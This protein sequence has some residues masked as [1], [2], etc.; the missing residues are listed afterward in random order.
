MLFYEQMGSANAEGDESGV[1]TIASGS[2]D[3][4]AVTNETNGDLD[5]AESGGAAL[6]TG[7]K[8][9]EAV[10]GKQE[11]NQEDGEDESASPEG[12]GEGEGDGVTS[13]PAEAHE[14]KGESDTAAEEGGT[15]GPPNGEI[16]I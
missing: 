10:E 2:P 12:Q 8:T 15:E 14:E 9:T 11:Q 7:N 1:S 13:G 5:A 4:D 6:S 3:D 16:W